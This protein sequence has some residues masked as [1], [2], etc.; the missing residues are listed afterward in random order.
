MDMSVAAV[1][2]RDTISTS[3]IGGVIPKKKIICIAR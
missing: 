2:M 1:D 3:K